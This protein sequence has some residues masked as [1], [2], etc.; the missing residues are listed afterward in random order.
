MVTLRTAR[1]ITTFLKFT[2]GKMVAT[3]KVGW[4][5]K[6]SAKYKIYFKMKATL[7]QIKCYSSRRGTAM[8]QE[9]NRHLKSDGRA[10]GTASARVHYRPKGVWGGCEVKLQ[11]KAKYRNTRKNLARSRDWAHDFPFARRMPHHWT[12]RNT[13]LDV[14]IEPIIFRSVGGRLTTRLTWVG[15][16]QME[17]C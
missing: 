6:R 11:G 3:N 2:L 9:Y 16:R 17:V 1:L 4:R 14:V 10:E 12:W 13:Q 5:S 15:I 7:Q 8:L